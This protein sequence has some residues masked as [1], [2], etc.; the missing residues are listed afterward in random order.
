MSISWL[1]KMAQTRVTYNSILCSLM[2]KQ[3]SLYEFA[4]HTQLLPNITSLKC[5]TCNNQLDYSED[6]YRC[7]QSYCAKR[8]GY[9][10]GIPFSGTEE[11]KRKHILLFAC[12]CQDLSV[13]DAANTAGVSAKRQQ[14]GTRY[15]GRGSIS[16]MS[17]RFRTTHLVHSHRWTRVC[18]GTENTT[19]DVLYPAT[20]SLVPVNPKEVGELT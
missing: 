2:N 10:Y 12:Y 9:F 14:N 6:G 8:F 3:T 19:S 1:I 17:K 11:Q 13:N 7:I 16:Y 5:D 20:G 4:I 15:S 18:M